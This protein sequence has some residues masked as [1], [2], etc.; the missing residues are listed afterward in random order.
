VLTRRVCCFVFLLV[1]C[2]E[3]RVPAPKVSPEQAA[4]AALA[5]YDSNHDGFLDAEEL[6]KSPALK[7]C[8]KVWDKDADGKLSLDE[9]TEGLRPYDRTVIGI[10]SVGC[11]VFLDDQPLPGATVTLVP[12]KFLGPNIKSAS[13]VSGPDGR[14]PLTIEGEPLPGVHRAL[15]RIVVSLKDSGGQETLPAKYNSQTTLGQQIAVDPEL[16]RGGNAVM[17]RL[18]SQ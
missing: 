5:E 17:L 3:A 2:S 6:E 18:S 15:Y 7:S 11:R 10:T 1:G 14:V 16:S 12:E 13:G 8:L 9:V 4:K